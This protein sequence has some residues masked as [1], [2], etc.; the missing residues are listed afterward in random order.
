MVSIFWNLENVL[1]FKW[2][3]KVQTGK[4]TSSNS[5]Y[6]KV[7]KSNRKDEK[8]S[9]FFLPI[10]IICPKLLDITSYS[11]VGSITQQERFPFPSFLTLWFFTWLLHNGLL[12]VTISLKISPFS[13]AGI[14]Q[15][16][17][18]YQHCTIVQLLLKFASTDLSSAS[19]D[20]PQATA[21]WS[22]CLSFK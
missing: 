13:S 10:S 4:I 11:L 20:V 15:K 12:F 22:F 8:Q 9:W 3:H 16:D 18:K 14:P 5:K 21:P 6:L 19:S 17:F 7:K 1:K 2:G